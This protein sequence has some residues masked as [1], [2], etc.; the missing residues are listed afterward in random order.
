MSKMVSIGSS[1]VVRRW[2]RSNSVSVSGSGVSYVCIWVLQCTLYH[3]FFFNYSTF[4]TG[5]VILVFLMKIFSPGM[6]LF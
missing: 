3:Q 5:R 1:S 4:P 6:N 2:S